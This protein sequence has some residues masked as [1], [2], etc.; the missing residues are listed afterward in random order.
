MT[1]DDIANMR[2][3]AACT[4]GHCL[5]NDPGS[6]PAVDKAWA[7]MDALY[8]LAERA[9]LVDAVREAWGDRWA[10]MVGSPLLG[11]VLAVNDGMGGS[12]FATMPQPTEEAAWRAALPAALAPKEQR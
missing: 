12:M 6:K 2:A 11:W 3:S 9:A 7:E 10:S 1:L 4:L 5:V 8:A